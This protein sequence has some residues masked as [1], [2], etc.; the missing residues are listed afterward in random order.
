MGSNSGSSEIHIQGPALYWSIRVGKDN[1]RLGCLNSAQCSQRLPRL[2]HLLEDPSVYLTPIG[3]F[4]RKTSLDEL[5]QLWS[6]LTGDMSFV[7]PRPAL[8]N[9]DDLIGLELPKGVHSLVPGLTGW[10]QINGQ[11]ELPIPEKVDLDVEY[12]NSHSLT[13]DIKIIFIDGRSSAET[14]GCLTEATRLRRPLSLFH[15]TVKCR[16]DKECDQRNA[17]TTD[18]RKSHWH[19]Y[20]G[21][22]STG[23]NHR[24]K[25][26]QRSSQLS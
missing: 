15:R 17:H 12:L 9:Q 25:G 2:R 7:G 24:K 18:Q 22:T 13:L 26:Q 1:K 23:A 11:D 16:N 4:L 19:H 6:I 20:I 8:H 3:S 21:T 5:P 14:L 10:A